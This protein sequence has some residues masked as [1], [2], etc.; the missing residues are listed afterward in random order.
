MAR[1]SAGVARSRLD[2]SPRCPGRG[3]TRRATCGSRS[4][5]SSPRHSSSSPGR[6]ADHLQRRP[7]VGTRP[8]LRRS[9]PAPRPPAARGGPRPGHQ[10]EPDHGRPVKLDLGEARSVVMQAGAFAEHTIC[11]ACGDPSAPSSNANRR[12]ARAV[13]RC[14]PA[15]H[16]ACAGLLGRSHPQDRDPGRRVAALSAAAAAADLLTTAAAR[17]ARPA[18]RVEHSGRV[19][20]E[21][22]QVAAGVD[23][24]I[25]AHDGDRPDSATQPRAADPLRRRPRTMPRAAYLAGATTGCRVDPGPAPSPPPY[26][27]PPPQ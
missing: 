18:A 19:E 20:H 15:A 23:L 8:P 26:P 5:P 21:V 17:L 7:A 12:S 9:G 2:G 27:P 14:R 22:M 16:G 6:T 13:A 4:I 11:T 1:S 10:P 3:G 24:L 25:C